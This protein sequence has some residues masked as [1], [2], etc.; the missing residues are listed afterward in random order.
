VTIEYLENLVRAGELRRLSPSEDE[1]STLIRKGLARLNDLAETEL[2]AVTRFDVAYNAA[3]ALSLAAL[4]KAGYRSES[5]YLVFQCTQ[6]TVDLTPENW[7]ILDLAHRKRNLAEYE[8]EFD[9]EDSLI[10]ALLR[11]TQLIA[12]RLQ[13]V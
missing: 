11:V 6:H 12:G 13:Q 8:G 5:R 3:Y 7:R 2:S 9:V 10:E 1:I 4:W